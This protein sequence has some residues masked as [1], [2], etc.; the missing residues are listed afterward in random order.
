[1]QFEDVGAVDVGDDGIDVDTG[2]DGGQFA[3]GGLG[4]GQVLG[5]VVFVEQHL[6][7]Q[8]ARLD[9]IAVDQPQMADAG[10]NQS[11]GQHRAQRATAA[12]RHTRIEQT[13]LTVFADAGETNLPAVAL[14][15]YVCRHASPFSTP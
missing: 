8:V 6:P 4:L 9:E 5:H 3:G 1:D 13:P 10:A 15:R 11:V 12:Q 2:V 14:Q 7:L